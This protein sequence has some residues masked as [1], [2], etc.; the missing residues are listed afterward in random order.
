MPPPPTYPWAS[1]PNRWP[2]PVPAASFRFPSPFSGNLPPLAAAATHGGAAVCVR[3]DAWV[4]LDPACPHSSADPM[5]EVGLLA[6]RGVPLSRRRRPAISALAARVGICSGSDAVR[7]VVRG[8]S[9][10]GSVGIRPIRRRDSL[11]ARSDRADAEFRIDGATRR[12]SLELAPARAP[13]RRH[14]PWFLSAGYRFSALAGGSVRPTGQRP[15]S[16]VRC[17]GARRVGSGPRWPPPDGVPPAWQGGPE[18]TVAVRRPADQR[19]RSRLPG[20]PKL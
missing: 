8:R 19:W 18:R 17:A 6:G 5:V 7:W 11:G 20:A 4:G 3:G 13:S 15:T 2:P 14:S 16:R 1:A 9:A 12:W 10:S